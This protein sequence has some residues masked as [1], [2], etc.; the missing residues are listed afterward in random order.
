MFQWVVREERYV[1]VLLVLDNRSG[2]CADQAGSVPCIKN[3]QLKSEKARL[4]QDDEIQLCTFWND[5]V[6]EYGDPYGQNGDKRD[7]Q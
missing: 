3:D 7:Q 6:I 2:H 1:T 4:M 5:D